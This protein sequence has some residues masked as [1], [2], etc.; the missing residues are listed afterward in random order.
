MVHAAPRAAAG[1]QRRCRRL[2]AARTTTLD[3]KYVTKVASSPVATASFYLGT[4]DVTR[5]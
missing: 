4:K 1:K 2:N 3:A 5:T